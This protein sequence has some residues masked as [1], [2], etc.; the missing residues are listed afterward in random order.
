MKP[1]FN[2]G[3]L[4]DTKPSIIKLFLEDGADFNGENDTDTPLMSAI[5]QN[6]DTIARL[7]IEHHIKN[8]IDLDK[9]NSDKLPP[10]IAAIQLS[11]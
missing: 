11:L 6:Q 3:Y 7:L 5:V 9:P 8:H 2:V 4:I 1:V 10:L